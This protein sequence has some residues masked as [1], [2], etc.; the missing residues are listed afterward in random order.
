[1]PRRARDQETP[2][3]AGCIAIVRAMLDGLPPDEAEELRQG[4]AELV[5]P[6]DGGTDGAG[7]DVDGS[8]NGGMVRNLP[9]GSAEDRRLAAD[10]RAR[11]PLTAREAADF[12]ARHPGA[13][14]IKIAF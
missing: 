14:R 1:M 11:R 13:A 12:A 6:M 2:T 7:P 9:T 4:L 3:A 5:E 8:T 10:R